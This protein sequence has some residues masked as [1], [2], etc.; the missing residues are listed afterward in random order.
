[1]WGSG[2]KEESESEECDQFAGY[3]GERNTKCP[4]I[5][6]YSLKGNACLEASE[7]A[8]DKWRRFK[9]LEGTCEQE[10]EQLTSGT[11]WRAGSVNSSFH[12]QRH[13]EP[14]FKHH[15]LHTSDC[16]VIWERQID[17]R[18]VTIQSSSTT[19][20]CSVLCGLRSNN[21]DQME[22]TNLWN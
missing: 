5:R 2:A 20:A 11:S 12:T 18:E 9:G 7:R 8:W 4:E 3:I 17:R 16:D 13:K 6:L 1:M 10:T 21:F 19:N 22:Q 15:S 14:I